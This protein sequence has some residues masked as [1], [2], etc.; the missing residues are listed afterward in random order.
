MKLQT[1]AEA[2]YQHDPSTQFL[3]RFF[4]KED[5]EEGMTWWSPKNNI[6]VVLE[7]P[8]GKEDFLSHIIASDEGYTIFT[9]GFDIEGQ[10]T[11]SLEGLD[12]Y[13]KVS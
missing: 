13:Q 10:H 5:E 2:R 11:D 3:N 6:V 1:I 9:K 4:E 7:N 8:N 12:V